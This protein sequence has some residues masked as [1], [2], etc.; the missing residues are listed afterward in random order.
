[1][2]LITMSKK[3]KD[4]K[5]WKDSLMGFIVGCLLILI[6]LTNY[7]IIYEEPS[8]TKGKVLNRFLGFLDESFGKEY[9][10]GFW[11]LVTVLFGIDAIISYLNSDD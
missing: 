5:P 9:V 10:F 8:G 6:Y 2:Q 11:I 1:M 7:E 3:N 4:P